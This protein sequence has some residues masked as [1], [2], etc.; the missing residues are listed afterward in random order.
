[1]VEEDREIF[2]V[3]SGSFIR[4]PLPSLKT[5]RILE[6]SVTKN[7]KESTG[8]GSG[9]SAKESSESSGRNI[10]DQLMRSGSIAGDPVD[11]L[12]LFLELVEGR[13]L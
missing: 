8:K 2:N 3:V 13:I 11:S 7:L 10:M 9:E 12:T 6:G 5:T 1:M 4:R